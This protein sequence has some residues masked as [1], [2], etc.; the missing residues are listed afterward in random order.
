MREFAQV[1]T[2]SLQL[3]ESLRPEQLMRTGHHPVVGE[4]SVQDL[5]YE[6]AY[7]DRD[8]LRQLLAN[9]QWLLW[10]WMGAAHGFY[11]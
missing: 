2:A 9:V 6:W 3:V 4:L 1:R 8:H 11:G 7:H 10:P 5:L